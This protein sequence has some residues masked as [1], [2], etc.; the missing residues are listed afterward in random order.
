MRAVGCEQA[1]SRAGVLRQDVVHAQEDQVELADAL[2]REMATATGTCDQM[3]SSLAALHA[4]VDETTAE[5]S[6]VGVKVVA[7]GIE[8]RETM[9]ALIAIGVDYLQGYFFGMPAKEPREAISL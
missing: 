1:E 8:D 7:E 6:Q 4:Q 9:K 5:L 3:A 2:Q